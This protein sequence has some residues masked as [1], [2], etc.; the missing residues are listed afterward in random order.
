MEIMI[1]ESTQL[2]NICGIINGQWF[3]KDNIVFNEYEKYLLIKFKRGIYENK[4]VIKNRIVM[5]KIDVPLVLSEL[6]INFVQ[7]YTI[8]DKADIGIYDFDEIKYNEKEGIIIITSGFPL[9]ITIKVY[10]LG[11]ELKDVENIIETKKYW[12]IFG[13][14]FEKGL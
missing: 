12:T 10:K 14:G 6:K 9:V 13:I 7:S 3:N 4:R 11:V 1:S 2:R 5:K 8:K